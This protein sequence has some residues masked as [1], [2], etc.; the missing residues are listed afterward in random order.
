MALPDRDALRAQLTHFDDVE[1]KVVGGMLAVIFA[2]PDRIRDREWMAEQY[3]QVALVTGQFEEAEHAHEGFERA[4]EWIRA[5]I[6]E[7]LGACIALFVHV[8]E[9]MR[10]QHGEE[11]GFSAADAMVQAL[12]YFDGPPGGAA[13]RGGTRQP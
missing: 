1:R 13:G 9:D 2:A 8:A 12:G 3:T 6:G 7:H 4:R 11:G 10:R 5:H